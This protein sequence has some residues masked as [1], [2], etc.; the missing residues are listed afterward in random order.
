MLVALCNHFKI[1]HIIH[2]MIKTS[3]SIFNM[4]KISEYGLCKCRK[5]T[6]Y[7]CTI[8][9]HVRGKLC[10]KSKMSYMCPNSWCH[11]LP[12]S[13]FYF[14]RQ[15]KW[16]ITK[17]SFYFYFWLFVWPLLCTV[18]E[19]TKSQKVAPVDLLLIYNSIKSKC[20][21]VAN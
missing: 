10:W 13:W 4:S 14:S 9:T 16:N 6:H 11:I 18:V 5:I 1:C 19:N 12:K 8:Y 20:P 21:F 15:P 3:F 7:L 17:N 2:S